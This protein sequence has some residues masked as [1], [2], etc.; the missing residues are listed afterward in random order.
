V[1]AGADVALLQLL[2][3]AV[4]VDRQAIHVH[5]RRVEVPGMTNRVRDPLREDQARRIGELFFVPR[6]QPR[7]L[8]DEG[9]EPREL[10][11][12]ERRLDVHHVVLVARHGD[13]VAG[14]PRLGEALP[15]LP[16]HPVE[17]QEGRLLE[18][19]RRR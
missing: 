9:V 2:H 12:A 1:E 5:E 7:P 8:R 4:P 17:L 11:E 18:P 3:E 19:P 15:R 10:V 16:V 13:V 14:T 6:G